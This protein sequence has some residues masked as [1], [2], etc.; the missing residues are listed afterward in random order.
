M[1]II[2]YCQH[3]LGVGH[4]FRTLEI[5]G[6]M[7]ACEVILVTG[8]DNIDVILP[9]HIRHIALAGLMM[10]KNF[11]HLHS[12]DP[13]KSVDD[14]KHERQ[15]CLLTL[16][17]Q[18]KPDMFFIELYPFGRRA[19]RF[20]LIPVLEYLKDTPE[21]NCK[22]VCSLRDILV[23]KEDTTKYETR[24]IEAVN[25][26]FDAV[27]VHSDPKLIK[28][29]ATFSRLD[30][31]RIPLIYTG[32][33]TPVPDHSK[34]RQ[35]RQK[36]GLSAKKKL[37]VASV[38]GGNV[39]AKLLKA[40]VHAYSD[41]PS[42][43][44]VILKVYTGPY[45]DDEDKQYLKLFECDGLE[46]KEFAENFV[47]LLGACDL[48]ISMAGYNT[49][50]N[51]VAADVPSLVWPFSQNREQRAR[52]QKII[53]YAAPMTILDNQ[54]LTSDKLSQLIQANLS[55]QTKKPH[56]KLDINGAFNTMEWI[57]EQIN[58]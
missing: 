15:K 44:D 41:L 54:D 32:F 40:V 55:G 1:K 6:A 13:K 17:E 48:S 9:D 16:I 33:V 14:V 43:K 35:I 12:V 24:V 11:T 36:L 51:I 18:E 45:M 53:R 20:E 5:A 52:A 29:A 10:D 19:F 2:I 34:V 4:F 23:E 37:I 21:T 49:C 26:W 7:E 56:M 38:G 57:K 50:M 22:V 30:K 28:L 42:K 46:V 8:G 47:S 39:G 27:L 31:I 3:V 25:K 58:H